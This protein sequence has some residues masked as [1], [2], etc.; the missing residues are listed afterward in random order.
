VT[1][2]LG[3]G[4]L[5]VVSLH[6]PREKLWGVLLSIGAPGIVL[7][8]VDLNAFEDWMRQEAR[9]ADRMIVP[10]TVFFPMTRL[11]RVERDESLGSIPSLADRFVATVGRDAGRSLG[12][13]APSARRR[14]TRRPRARRA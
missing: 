3:P 14:G 7:R 10:S 9:G 1:T 8:G 5:V 12:W 4:D 13:K 11:E 6:T 2:L